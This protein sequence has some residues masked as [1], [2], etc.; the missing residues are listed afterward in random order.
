MTTF[1]SP[2]Q[3]EMDPEQFGLEPVESNRRCEIALCTRERE[4]VVEYPT[5]GRTETCLRHGLRGRAAGAENGG[6]R[7]V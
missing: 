7:D 2:T 1:D 5:R 4:V 6:G 3:Q